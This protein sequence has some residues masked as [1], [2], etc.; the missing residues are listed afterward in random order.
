MALRVRSIAG[1]EAASGPVVV[2]TGRGYHSGWSIGGAR[3]PVSTVDTQTAVTVVPDSTVTMEFGPQR[4]Y[5][6]LFALMIVAVG[7]CVM[8][9]MQP[10]RWRR[11]SWLR[12]VL[13]RED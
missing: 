12:D 3:S 13:R 7:A 5:R 1:Q 6:L 10:W 8:L 11:G 9:A 4:L 2:T